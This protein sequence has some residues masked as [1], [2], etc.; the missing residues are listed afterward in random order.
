MKNKT[1]I[2]T[3]IFG[4]KDNLIE[5][6]FVPKGCDFV[7]FTDQNFKSDVWEVIKIEPEFEDPVRNARM[8]KV[9]PHKFLSEYDISI[10]IDGNLL[11]RGDVNNLIKKYLSRT[12]L[13]IFDHTQH[14]K[15]WKKLFWVK[16]TE[17]WRDCIY[18]EAKSLLEYGE[19]GKY[20][21]DP[22]LMKEQVEKYKMEGY[23]EHNGLV[24]SMIILRKHNEN[25]IIKTMKDWWEEIKNHSRRDQL[26]FNYVA[27]KNKLNFV[28]IKGD[29][30]RNKYF[31]HRK[32]KIRKNY[33]F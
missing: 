4:G 19:N 25:D 14:K 31:L 3:A 8:Y 30:R 9:L 13:A 5:P 18:E 10:W 21:D 23:P 24:V 28:Y 1:V 26:S 33:V 12:N 29:S 32:H 22:E 27:W 7:C 15:R 16:N 17:D 2:Y 20:K 6:K 11:V